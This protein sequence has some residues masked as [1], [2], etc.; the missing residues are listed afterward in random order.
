MT[1]FFVT[2]YKMYVIFYTFQ[3]VFFAEPA[4]GRPVAT[5]KIRFVTQPG[6]EK[7]SRSAKDNAHGSLFVWFTSTISF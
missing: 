5:A 4:V 7:A 1:E 2:L 6:K 3:S